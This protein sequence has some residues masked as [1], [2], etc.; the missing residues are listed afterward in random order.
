MWPF[1]LLEIFPP[2]VPPPFLEAP[3]KHVFF[4]EQIQGFAGGSGFSPP[5]FPSGFFSRFFLQVPLFCVTK[6][7]HAAHQC[8][9]PSPPVLRVSPFHGPQGDINPDRVKDKTLLSWSKT[10]VF[11]NPSPPLLPEQV[12]LLAYPLDFWV[13]RFFWKTVN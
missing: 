5:F 10:G 1:F 12:R 9:G 6:V 8:I 11:Q 3:S 7:P 4:C 2:L 13:P